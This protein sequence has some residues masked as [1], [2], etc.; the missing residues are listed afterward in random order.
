VLGP[1]PPPWRKHKFYRKIA[2]FWV[3]GA[4]NTAGKTVTKIGIYSKPPPKSRF[5]SKFIEIYHYS[6]LRQFIATHY[7][8]VCFIF[9]SWVLYFY[10]SIYWNSVEV[11]TL[12]FL[13]FRKSVHVL[14]TFSSG[15]HELLYETDARRPLK[16]AFKPGFRQ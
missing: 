7:R 10:S 2:F 3:L 16:G 4:F 15:A 5:Y 13:V 6:W 8:I 12:V 14:R 1:R 11:F 9:W